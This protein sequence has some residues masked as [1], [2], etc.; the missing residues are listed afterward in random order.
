LRAELNVREGLKA[1]L[2]RDKRLVRSGFVRED[3]IG[4]ERPGRNDYEGWIGRWAVFAEGAKGAEGCYSSLEQLRFAAGQER[5]IARSVHDGAAGV[6]KTSEFRE[7][8]SGG[9][10]RKGLKLHLV[11]EEAGVEGAD[12]SEPPIEGCE[13]A[14]VVV[15]DGVGGLN[16]LDVIG[17]KSLK[18]EWIFI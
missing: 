6:Q 13:L 14:G 7:V 18:G 5:G 4:I 17:D 12:P 2:I 10:D 16:A 3:G 1:R 9:L 15:F 11:V 8:M